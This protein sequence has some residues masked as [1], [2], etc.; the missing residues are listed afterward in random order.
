MENKYQESTKLLV[1]QMK[2]ECNV[3]INNMEMENRKIKFM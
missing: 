3:K 1:Q 2:N